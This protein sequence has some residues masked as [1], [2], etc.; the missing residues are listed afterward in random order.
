VIAA[1]TPFDAFK[2]GQSKQ[3]PIREDWQEVK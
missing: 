1:K 2:M 3:Y